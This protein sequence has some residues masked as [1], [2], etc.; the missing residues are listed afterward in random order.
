MPNTAR[1]LILVTGATG[2]Q[3]GAVFRHLRKRNFPVRVLTRDPGK[4]EARALLGK[5][6]EVVQG[7]LKD[8]AS[9]TKALEDVYGVYS[10]QNSTEGAESEILQ[11]INLADAAN[12]SG[13]SHLV[14]SSVGSADQNTGIPHF[15]SK[16]RIEE[17]IRGTGLRYTIFR[18]VFFME[19]WLARKKQIEEGK[20]ALPLNPGTRLQMIAVDDIGAFVALAFEHP[21]HWEKRAVELAG[22]ELSMT[23]LARAFSR[24]A[25]R[26]IE[27]VQVPWDQFKQQ[28]GPEM[29]TMFRWFQDVGYHVDIAAL[30]QEFPELTNLERWLNT[31]GR[32]RPAPGKSATA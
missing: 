25:G 22:D 17:H 11:G 6:V 4:P 12:R 3:G 14:Y 21:G 18:P 24:L 13:V 20:L 5:G 28:A 10:V 16:F 8:P 32:T 29:T 23:E 26:D 15:E 1:K 7:D 31:N 2:K 9:L 19:N 27:L 30:R